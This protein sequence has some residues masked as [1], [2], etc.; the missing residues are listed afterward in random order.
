MDINYELCGTRDAADRSARLHA[1]RPP[2]G[3]P[4]EPHQ[5]WIIIRSDMKNLAPLLAVPI[6]EYVVTFISLAAATT[7]LSWTTEGRP[8]RRWLAEDRGRREC[9]RARFPHHTHPPIHC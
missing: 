1:T 2:T 7:L 9:R 6:S 5:H 3:A 4:S 8:A